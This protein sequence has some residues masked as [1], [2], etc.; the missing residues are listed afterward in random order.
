[1]NHVFLFV[2]ETLGLNL[3]TRQKKPKNP[4]F[5]GILENVTRFAVRITI[6]SAMAESGAWF[7]FF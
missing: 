2:K 5:S 3:K 7:S 6:S 4:S 1:M